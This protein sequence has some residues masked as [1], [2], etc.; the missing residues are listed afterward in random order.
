MATSKKPAPSKMSEAK[1]AKFD[2]AKGIKEGSKAD[3]K[4]DK[5][6]GVK[7]AKAKKC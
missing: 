1:D 7:D 3:M 2:K 5:A 4:K 6:M